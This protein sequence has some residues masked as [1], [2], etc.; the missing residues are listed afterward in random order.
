MR[1][2]IRRTPALYFR[3]VLVVAS[4]SHFAYGPANAL[5]FDAHVCSQNRFAPQDPSLSSFLIIADAA[6]SMAPRPRDAVDAARGKSGVILRLREA[7]QWGGS[8]VFCVRDGKG[9][10][11]YEQVKNWG[12]LMTSGGRAHGARRRRRRRRDAPPR[13]GRLV[14]R[15]GEGRAVVDMS[16]QIG[17]VI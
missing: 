17:Q 11:S 14:L 10:G 16:I 4:V 12:R 9:R 2:N 3:L 6:L 5:C 15:E 13:L 1:I 8:R 7:S